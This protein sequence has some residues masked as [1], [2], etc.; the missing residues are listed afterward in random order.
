MLDQKLIESRMN[1]QIG[2]IYRNGKEEIV[3]A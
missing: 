2:A 1:L 3:M